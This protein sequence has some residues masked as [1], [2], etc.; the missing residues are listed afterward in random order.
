MRRLGY[1]QT[2][3]AAGLHKAAEVSNLAQDFLGGMDP[4]GV[5]TNPYGRE[6]ERAGLSEGE[7]SLKHLAA[8][9]GGLVGGAGLVPAAIFGSV[10]GA[11]GLARPGGGIKGRLARGA[12]GFLEG[13]KRPIK[14]VLEGRTAQRALERISQG[15]V[16]VEPD[17]LEALQYLAKGALGNVDDL[18]A[19]IREVP[20]LGRL[21]GGFDQ[22]DAERLSD[23]S[24]QFGSTPVQRHAA[25]LLNTQLK[26]QLGTGQAQ[27]GLGGLIGAGGAAYQYHSGRQTERAT[28]PIGRLKRRLGLDVG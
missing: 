16:G 7:H 18:R 9:T 27:L 17:E 26:N 10:D 3:T 5:W 11:K 6:A 8:T 28:S 23:L 4:L 12:T 22:L 13:A 19:Q 25:A 20:F 14:S 1:T 21:T 24:R 2:L 15:G